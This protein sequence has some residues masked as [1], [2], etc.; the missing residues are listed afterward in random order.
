MQQQPRNTLIFFI[1]SALVFVGVTLL[2]NWLWPPKP[3]PPAPPQLPADRWL[4]ADLAARTQAALYVSPALPGVA[5]AVQLAT[6][7]RV[8]EWA[9]TGRFRALAAR[10]PEDKPAA[11]P[12]PP[13]AVAKLPAAP[14]EVIP[15]GGPGFNYSLVLTSRGAGVQSLTLNAFE[16][17]TKM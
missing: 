10:K 3:R 5:G 13:P 11:P 14:H 7:A 12:Q 17:A 8:A 9:V 1:L 16:G 15:M 6:E 4:A 2:Q